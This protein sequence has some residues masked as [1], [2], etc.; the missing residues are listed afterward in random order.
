MKYSFLELFFPTLKLPKTA[1]AALEFGLLLTV[2]VLTAAIVTL[3][4]RKTILAA[5]T[6]WLKRNRH[7]W[8][9]PLAANKLL[10]RL[11]W[12]IPL[13][14]L[15]LAT[16]GFLQPETTIYLIVKR[17][18]TSGFVIVA[19]VSFSALFA[20]INDIHRIVRK[21]KGTSLRGY[22]DAAKII[23]YTV[24]AIF[25]VSIF[26]G[27]SP[28]GILSVLGGLTAVL[29]LVFKDVILGFVAS[30]QLTATDMVRIGD[31]VQMDQ[32]GADG[33]VIDISIHSV[34]VQN[35]DK[36]ITTIPPYA[37]VSN[38]VKNWRG[39]SESGGR[40]IKRAINIDLQSIC[41]CDDPMLARLSEIDLIR[42]YINTKQKEI[43]EINS[44]RDSPG[45][46]PI[47]SRQQTNI[48]IFRAYV[49]AYL[50]QNPHIHKHMTFLVRQ[51]A[52]TDR[53]LPLEIYAFCR[54][55]AWASYEA[56]QADIF[57]HLLAAV[58]YFGLRVFQQPSGHD[59]R[60]FTITKPEPGTAEEQLFSQ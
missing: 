1:V 43:V 51:L 20:T 39:M 48:G 49:I 53:G 42:D 11:S 14:I 36:T 38:A 17:F 45:A 8:D 26:T 52:P 24:G 15:S 31:W 29:L 4:F 19:M 47:N 58:P 40:R 41:F 33:D 54:D 30:V 6:S 5:I 59:F 44:Q 46:S 23:T 9:D 35:W 32:Y 27:K 22:T 34:R 21:E 10:S 60:I 3:L 7:A 13:S 55:K 16:D 56:I 12:F 57:D 25:L 50:R 28:W 2:I 37:L 18:I